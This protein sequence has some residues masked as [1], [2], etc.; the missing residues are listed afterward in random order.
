[1]LTR[2]NGSEVN[3]KSSS[4]YVI[5]SVECNNNIVSTHFHFLASE[6]VATVVPFANILLIVADN[7]QI[8]ITER[9]SYLFNAS[10]KS[11]LA[12]TTFPKSGAHFFVIGMLF[13]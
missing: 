9:K 5:E 6:L 2:W 4:F 7:L 11:E 10:L 8:V 1:M 13:T 12:F 3:V